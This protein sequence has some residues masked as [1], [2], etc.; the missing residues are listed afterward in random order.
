[1]SLPHS[2]RLY[3]SRD[4]VD[5]KNKGRFRQWQMAY[6]LMLY[7][8]IQGTRMK[9]GMGV[10]G[11]ESWERRW[12]L[13]VGMGSDWGRNPGRLLECLRLL[14]T[15]FIRKGRRDIKVGLTMRENNNSRHKSDA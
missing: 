5:Q 1:M 3:E 8:Y 11:E 14:V 12:N 15:L 10:K 4:E 9:V 13:G 2:L 7:I 6:L